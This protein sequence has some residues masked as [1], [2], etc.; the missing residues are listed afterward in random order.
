MS[1]KEMKPLTKEQIEYV[2]LKSAVTRFS[3]ILEMM[4]DGKQI[5]PCNNYDTELSPSNVK[6]KFE[7]MLY[8]YL[9]VL[10]KEQAEYLKNKL[11][12]KV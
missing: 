5:S 6:F 11:D 9:E 7:Q 12:E 1:D 4:L 3:G 8:K 2:E 10:Q